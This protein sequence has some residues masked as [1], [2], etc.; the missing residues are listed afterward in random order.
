MSMGRVTLALSR[1]GPCSSSNTS[2]LISV[3]TR[4]ASGPSIVISLPRTNGLASND[5]SMS[6][7]NSSRCPRRPTI[8]WFSGWI[9]TWVWDTGFRF[10]VP[11]DG[12]PAIRE[13]SARRPTEALAAEDVKVQVRDGIEGIV[14]HVQHQAV[15]AVRDALLARHIL[16]GCD[17]LD[18]PLCV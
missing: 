17:H 12:A 4:A 7:S 14:A 5:A 6:R 1:T 8:R 9:L 2:S 10:S 15:A 13:S 11:A 16:G 18:Q 3:P